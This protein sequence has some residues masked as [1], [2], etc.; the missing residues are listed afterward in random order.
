MDKPAKLMGITQAA[1]L[2]GVHPLTLRSWA[3]KRYVPHYRTPGGHRRFRRDELLAFIAEMNQGAPED[4]V[5][6]AARQ[7]VQEA[8]ST[9]PDDANPAQPVHRER[10]AVAESQKQVMRESGQE[11]LRLTIQYVSGAEGGDVLDRARDIGRSYG[12][13]ATQHGMSICE[14]VATF[15]FFQ[16]TIINATFDSQAIDA[17]NPQLYRRLNRFFNEVLLATVRAA[18]QATQA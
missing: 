13:F 2:L 8:I 9:L 11:L 10:L 7:A 5:A 1:K 14:T 18:E 17:T 3:E 4:A 6:A 15:N 12:E 16:D